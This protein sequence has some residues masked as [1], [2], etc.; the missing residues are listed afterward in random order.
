MNKTPAWPP[1]AEATV[2]DTSR[3]RYTRI[4]IVLH[5]LLAVGLMYQLTLGI[6]MDGVPKTPPGLRAEWFNWHKSV[7]L[8][9]GLLILLRG[10]W[11]LTHAR[12]G[13]PKA[14]PC[15]QQQAAGISHALLYVCMFTMPLSGF[16][17]SSFTQYPIK[18]FGTPLPRLWQAEPDLKNLL[19]SVHTGTSYVFIGLIVLH[20]MATLWHVLRRDGVFSRIWPVA[21][22]AGAAA[23]E[24]AA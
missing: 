14:L 10:V 6:W 19:S 20:V 2:Q 24:T 3:L 11:R 12:P 17:G 18:F 23:P 13:W 22:K 5:W 1:F 21:Q 16:L 7:G 9:L 15:W 8:L 4:A